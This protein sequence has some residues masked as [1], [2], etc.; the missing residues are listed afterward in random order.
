MF[1][2]VSRAFFLQQFEFVCPAVAFPVKSLGF[3][4]SHATKAD[5]ALKESWTTGPAEPPFPAVSVTG[6]LGTD[7]Q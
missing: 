7:L 6:V 4:A 1:C 3:S 2:L 5:R